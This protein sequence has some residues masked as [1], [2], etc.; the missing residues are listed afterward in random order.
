MKKTLLSFTFGL[1]IL[2]GAASCKC[3]S[4]S[5]ETSTSKTNTTSQ[6]STSLNGTIWVLESIASKPFIQTEES[7]VSEITLSFDA[8]DNHFVTSDGCNTKGGEFTAQEGK[9]SMHAI[10]ETK[11]YCGPEVM[12]NLYVIPF[13]EVTYYEVTSDKLILRDASQKV[14]ATYKKSKE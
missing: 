9:L 14:L 13:N 2:T 11:M 5:H 6:M 8:K 10:R 12:K 1:F 4:K 7:R 3:V